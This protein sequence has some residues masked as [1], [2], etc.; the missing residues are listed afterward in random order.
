MKLIIFILL[1]LTAC[2]PSKQKLIDSDF[3][4]EKSAI[5]YSVGNEYSLEIKNENK[6][7]QID[8]SDLKPWKVE[9]CNVDGHKNVIAIGVYK[10]TPLHKE[11]TK[12]VFF[13][14]ID[15][16]SEAL[17]P[18]LRISRLYNPMV[19]FTMKDIDKDGLDEIIAVEKNIDSKY[20]MGGYDFTNFA[21]E[22]NYSSKTY[23]EEIKLVDDY[24]MI[25]DKK[26]LLKIKGDEILCV[27]KD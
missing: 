7:F 23:D 1:F 2:S 9:F 16:K 3:K 13:Y 20:L 4:G 19:N 25:N 14:N 8:V 22:R 17:R 12:R 10:K 26:Y 27:E 5:I 6:E 18:K 15:Y 11:E 21:F 24:V